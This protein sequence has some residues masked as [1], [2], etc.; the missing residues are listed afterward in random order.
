[1][2]LLCFFFV[3][4]WRWVCVI[5]IGFLYDF[6]CKFGWIWVVVIVAGDYEWIWDILFVS[7]CVGVDGG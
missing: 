1:M 4:S 2:T 6:C 5:F 3:P 7:C